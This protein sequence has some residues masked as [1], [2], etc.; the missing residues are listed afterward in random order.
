MDLP[1]EYEASLS[2]DD[3]ENENGE[4]CWDTNETYESSSGELTADN[5]VN[6]ALQ[7]FQGRSDLLLEKYVQKVVFISM[8]SCSRKD[9]CQL[10]YD[11][12]PNC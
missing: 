4:A 1:N 2:P 5:N 12:F 3:Q 7:H 10:I 11:P 9:Q 6:E 8:I